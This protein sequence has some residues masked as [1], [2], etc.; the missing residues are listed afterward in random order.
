[1]PRLAFL[2]AARNRLRSWRLNL[3]HAVQ[4]VLVIFLVWAIDKAVTY[5]SSQFSGQAAVRSPEAVFIPAIPDC[6]KNLFLRVGSF[7]P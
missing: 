5:S 1:M 3:F 4:S 2:P 7:N 6:T